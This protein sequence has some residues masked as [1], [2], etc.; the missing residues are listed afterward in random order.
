MKS[1]SRGTLAAVITG[2]V[3]AVG[4]G[5]TT[6][7]V[8]AESVPVVVPLDGVEKSH[9]AKL[10]KTG[11]EVPLPTQGRPEQ[12]RYVGG[13]LTP[14][15]T[16]PQVPLRAPLPGPEVDTPLPRSAGK[17]SER[18]AVSG[19]VTDL[20]TMTPGLSLDAPL[21]A[22][23]HRASRLQ[24]LKQPQAALRTPLLRTAPTADARLGKP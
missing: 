15:N 12:P 17:A 23:D 14:E 18:A 24:T 7:A 1:T 11:G 21:T 5:A 8:A 16:V 13:R 6:P 4:A 19:P 20:R 22:P 2:V 3:T 9:H 10:P